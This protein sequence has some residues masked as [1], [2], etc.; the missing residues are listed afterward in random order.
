MIVMHINIITLNIAVHLI[1]L[2][3]NSIQII[4]FI[5]LVDC[6]VDCKLNANCDILHTYVIGDLFMAN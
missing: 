4:Q 2:N 5:W 1:D 3:L 6:I